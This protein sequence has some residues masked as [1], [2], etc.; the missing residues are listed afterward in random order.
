M[1]FIT[2][3]I[4]IL[5]LCMYVYILIWVNIKCRDANKH[6]CYFISGLVVFNFMRNSCFILTWREVPHINSL[7]HTSVFSIKINQLQRRILWIS[8]L[9]IV[10]W[11]NFWRCWLWW[12]QWVSVS[13]YVWGMNLLKSSEFN[14]RGPVYIWEDPKIKFKKKEKKMAA[15]S[16]LLWLLIHQ[17]CIIEFRNKITGPFSIIFSAIFLK[18]M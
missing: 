4:A 15:V 11:K 3:L 10:V 2:A 16:P 6:R 12:N 14:G 5:C 18:K 17:Y 8:V 9:I 7:G 1:Y 13:V